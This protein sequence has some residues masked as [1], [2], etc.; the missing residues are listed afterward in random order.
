MLKVSFLL[1]EVF[2]LLLLLLL[3]ALQSDV[4]GLFSGNLLHPFWIINHS[5]LLESGMRN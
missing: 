5:R 4:K 1:R 3:F 2:P